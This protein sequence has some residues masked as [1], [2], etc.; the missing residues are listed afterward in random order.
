MD[1]INREIIDI[2]IS[3][4]RASHEEIASKLGLSRPAIHERIRKLEKEGIIK[5][6]KAVVDWNKLEQPIQAFIYIKTMGVDYK[7]TAAS[8]I[9]VKVE[10][11]AVEECHRLAGVW[12]F[13]VK[14]RSKTPQNLTSL[15]D[16][17]RNIPGV[18]ETSTTLL[19]TAVLENGFI[20]Y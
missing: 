17:I 2:L 9:K 16:A 7:V 19:L 15:I 3:K 1:S 20:E 11:T 8:I 6:Y 4:G 18:I 10:H 13:V 5:G 14:V 12:C